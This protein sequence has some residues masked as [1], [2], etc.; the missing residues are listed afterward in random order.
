[1]NVSLEEFFISLEESKN[2]FFVQ[3]K[4]EY[5]RYYQLQTNII[6]VFNFKGIWKVAV[7][8]FDPSKAFDIVDQNAP[9]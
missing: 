5:L 1:M 6:T 2:S 3:K 8:F 4:T 9:K 7:L